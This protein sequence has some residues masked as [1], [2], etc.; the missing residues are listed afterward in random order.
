MLS[1]LTW[2]HLLISLG[3]LAVVAFVIVMIIVAVVRAVRKS[4][5]PPVH[6]LQVPLGS[7]PVPSA[8]PTVQLQKLAELRAEGLIS[9]AEHEAK[10]TEILGRL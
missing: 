10:R 7:R 1:N 2:W 8:D 4:A 3:V 6:S 9:D 5:A